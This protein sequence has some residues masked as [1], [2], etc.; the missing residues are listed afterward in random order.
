V[1]SFWVFLCSVVLCWMP[2][3]WVPLYWVSFFL[4]IVMLSFIIVSAGWWVTLGL[5]PLFCVS[6][7]QT[8]WHQADILDWIFGSL[9]AS[10]WLCLSACINSFEILS[11][12]KSIDFTIIFI[13]VI[14]G[15]SENKLYRSLSG[16]VL[17]YFV[18]GPRAAWNCVNV[19]KLF[20]SS[21]MYRA[22]KLACFVLA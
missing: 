19:I 22:N 9:G 11:R 4:N 10:D 21:L 20:S 8:S 3:C 14:Y 2:L 13:L 18:F 1:S 5:L 7:G 17:A 12:K 6:L 16:P 15:R